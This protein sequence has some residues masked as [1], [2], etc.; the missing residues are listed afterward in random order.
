MNNLDS[1]ATFTTLGVELS[2]PLLGLNL[3]ESLE[4][5]ERVFRTPPSTRAK[6]VI[7]TVR[8]VGSGKTRIL[9]ELR[10]SLNQKS[11]TVAIAITY[12]F[13][14]AIMDPEICLYNNQS[15][16]MVMSV[17][18]RMMTVLYELPL[19]VLVNIFRESSAISKIPDGAVGHL[20]PAFITHFVTQMRAQGKPVENV[21]IL[22]DETVAAVDTITRC[23]RIEEGRD[24]M[25]MVRDSVL[26]RPITGGINTALV[27][28]S[29]EISPIGQTSSSRITLPLV[30]AASLPVREVVLTWWLQGNPDFWV[31]VHPLD[32]YRLGVLASCDNN[33]PSLLETAAA[34]VASCIDVLT[35]G[36]G[37]HIDGK[38]VQ[39]LWRDLDLTLV[40]RYSGEPSLPS[41]KMLHAIVFKEPIPVDKECM[42]LIRNSVLTNSLRSFMPGSSIYPE[43][44]LLTLVKCAERDQRRDYKLVGGAVVKT[45]RDIEMVLL[46]QNPEGELL[47]ILGVDWTLVRMYTA[48]FDKQSSTMSLESL[49]SFENKIGTHSMLQVDV[50]GGVDILTGNNRL[51]KVY[52]KNAFIGAIN[53]LTLSYRVS[54]L[55]LP[56]VEGQAFDFALVMSSEDG[57]VLVFID[58]KSALPSSVDI[59]N[60][61]KLPTPLPTNLSVK[62]SLEVIQTSR[63]MKA[64]VAGNGTLLQL[65]LPGGG[66][67]VV[68]LSDIGRAFATG[69]FLYLYMTTYANVSE[70]FSRMPGDVEKLKSGAD[71]EA[72]YSKCVHI[73]KEEATRRYFGPAYEVYRAARDTTLS[74]HSDC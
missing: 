4:L 23:F 50:T 45:M 51:P 37:P 57:P 64:M 41:A 58:C 40:G 22:I 63:D 36:H 24:L 46:S 15:V 16:F 30:L 47:E 56:S 42:A 43:T 29:L 69:R 71:D 66:V 70:D 13:N 9:E 19:E 33:M 67:E 44:C 65:P 28:S 61:D 62:Q 26:S 6:P 60:P 54:T 68:P 53:S 72:S 49:F 55:L 17:I 18:M 12:N 35:D 1:M 73:M 3:N 10:H 31:S 32:M 38:F 48:G 52:S 25:S 11:N 59:M 39:A 21:V 27:V 74:S 34:F 8:G 5:V 2:N 14:T 7:A 20:L